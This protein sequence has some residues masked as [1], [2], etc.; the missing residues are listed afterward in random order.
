MELD[1]T[2]VP[3]AKIHGIG[4]VHFPVPND[5]RYARVDCKGALADQAI[6]IAVFAFRITYEEKKLVSTNVQKTDISPQITNRADEIFKEIALFGFQGV[7]EHL[8]DRLSRLERFCIEEGLIW[9]ADILSELQEEYSKYVSHDSLFDPDQVVY[10]LGEWFVRTDALKSNQKEVPSLA[11]SGDTKIYSSEL[12]SRSLTGL[13][14]GIQVLKKGFVIRSYFADPKS[15]EVLLY[16]RFLENSSEEVIGNIPVLKGVSLLDFGKSS[17]IGSS[18][19]KTAAGRLQ[20]SN[21]A[22]LNPQTFYFDSLSAKIFS[23][24]FHKTIR[25]ISEKPPRSLGP[26]W[27]AGNFY[28][29]KTEQFDDFYFDTVL[30]RFHLEVTDKNGSTA[31]VYLPYFGKAAGGL[32]NLK[33]ALD[34]SSLRYV[35]GIADVITGRLRIRPVSFVIEQDGSRKMLQPYLD[36]K[37]ESIG[38]NFQI[39]DRP[40]REIDPLKEYIDELKCMISEVYLVGLKRSHNINHWRQL[41]QKSE[42]LGLKRISTLL[43]CAIDSIQTTDVNHVSPIFALTALICLSREIEIDVEY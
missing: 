43:E 28:V 38:S 40:P 31:D 42:T 5:I 6:A 10:L 17:I 8:K 20:F 30:Q 19:K 1:R 26:R 34:D 2:G 37:S 16:E 32:E 9:P 41:I 11:I 24:D 39:L 13:G 22:T 18:I 23:D 12:L 4:T 33:N 35:C 29:F 15:E 21:K 3:F 25:I 27:A 36:P 7:G 14:S